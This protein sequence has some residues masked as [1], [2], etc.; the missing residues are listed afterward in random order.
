MGLFAFAQIN[1][2]QILQDGFVKK[3]GAMV[4]SLMRRSR[5]ALST[6]ATSALAECYLGWRYFSRFS[7][8]Q[9]MKA[10]NDRCLFQTKYKNDQ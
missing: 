5:T 2:L 8:L 9:K 7:L 10:S 6:P 3:R 4:F 1:L